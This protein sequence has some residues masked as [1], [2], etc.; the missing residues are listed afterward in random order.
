MPWYINKN[1]SEIVRKKSCFSRNSTFLRV[2]KNI[3]FI[4]MKLVPKK[5]LYYVLN[6]LVNEHFYRINNSKLYNVFL[7][8]VTI[9]FMY[10]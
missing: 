1:K 9:I 4:F 2:K 5:G 8:Y 10:N 7:E 3:E 6:L